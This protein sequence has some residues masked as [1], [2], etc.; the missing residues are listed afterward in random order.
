MFVYVC[1]EFGLAL[2]SLLRNLSCDRENNFTFSSIL[3]VFGFG[4]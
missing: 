2:A 4:C 1:V 3:V